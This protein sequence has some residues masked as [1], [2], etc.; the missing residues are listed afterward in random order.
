METV[1][2]VVTRDLEITQKY[3][4][5]IAPHFQILLKCLLF[6]DFSVIFSDLVVN[7][8]RQPLKMIILMGLF[9]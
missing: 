1:E 9:V 5:F 7:S 6:S 4:G 8:E 3:R 2:T